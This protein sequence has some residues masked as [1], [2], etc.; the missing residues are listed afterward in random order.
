MTRRCERLL[1]GLIELKTHLYD[2]ILK[3][4]PYRCLSLSL[5]LDNAQY[6]SEGEAFVLP[7]TLSIFPIFA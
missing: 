5:L 1:S 4:K 3:G 6:E 2:H 7:L